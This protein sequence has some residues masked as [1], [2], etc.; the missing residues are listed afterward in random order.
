MT[1]KKNKNSRSTINDYYIHDARK[2]AKFCFEEFLIC[3]KLN[4]KKRCYDIFV[5]DRLE[6]DNGEIKI[7]DKIILGKFQRFYPK[8]FNVIILSE[9]VSIFTYKLNLLQHFI[10]KKNL[11]LYSNEYFLYIRTSFLFCHQQKQEI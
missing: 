5:R 1:K 7:I 2:S 10:R 6:D 3:V 9:I 11:T 8:S 4:E